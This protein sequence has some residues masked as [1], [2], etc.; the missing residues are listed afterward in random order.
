M[1]NKRNTNNYNGKATY[2]PLW[3]D[4][5]RQKKQPK[6][7]RRLVIKNYKDFEK[8]VFYGNKKERIK[9]V[10]SLYS[11]DIYLLKNAF[12]VKFCKKLIMGAWKINKS[13]KQSFHKMKGKCQNFHRLIDNK[14]TK[15]YAYNHVKHAFYFFPW[16]KDPINMYE[17]IYKKWRTFKC[18]GGFKYNEYEKNTAKDRVVDRFQIVHYPA[19]AGY[20]EPHCDP[21]HNQRVIISGFLSERGKDYSKG[22]FYYYKKDKSIIDCD[23]EIEVGDMLIGY[24][25][26]IHGVATVDPNK[27]VNFNSPRGRWFLGLYSNDTDIVK[28]RRTTKSHSDKYPSPNLPL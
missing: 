28:K 22:G 8:K 7:A 20:L 9:L 2:R 19:G 21:H 6:H 23:D 26:I 24:A 10:K 25:T 5:E 3:L 14:I 1:I 17:E 13:H 27:K 11:G 12:S 18:F 4:L 15:K 16:N